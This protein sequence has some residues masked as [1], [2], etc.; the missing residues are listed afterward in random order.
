MSDS[1]GASRK[2]GSLVQ[3]RGRGKKKQ[4]AR[5]HRYRSGQQRQ[6][7]AAGGGR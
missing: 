4:R 2:T 5:T 7:L 3:G 1:P 6:G